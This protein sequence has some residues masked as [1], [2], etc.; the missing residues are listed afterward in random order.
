MDGVKVT[1]GSEEKLLD[2]IFND[3]VKTKYFVR[4]VNKGNTSQKL[5][6]LEISETWEMLLMFLFFKGKV[7]QLA[8]YVSLPSFNINY[9]TSTNLTIK[10]WS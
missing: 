4:N 6:A 5:N 3:Y 1:I 10:Q 8:F 9:S 2:A 7:T